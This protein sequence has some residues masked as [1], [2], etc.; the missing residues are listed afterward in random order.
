MYDKKKYKE[1]LKR[2]FENVIPFDYDTI[3]DIIKDAD[4]NVTLAIKKNLRGTLDKF[5]A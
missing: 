1:L 2:A 4:G 5:M 3:A